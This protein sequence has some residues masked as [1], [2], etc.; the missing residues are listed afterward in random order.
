VATV[1]ALT[2]PPQITDVAPLPASDRAGG[3]LGLLVQALALGATVA[4]I[5]LGR[6]GERTKRSINRGIRHALTLIV[7]AAASGGAVLWAA[8][9]F[10][11]IGG[12]AAGRLYLDFG[13]L[14]LAI[15]ASTAA[16]VALVGPAGALLG[17]LYF[18]LGVI[19]SGSSILPEFLPTFGRVVGQ[20]LPTGA[21][22]TAIRESLYFPAAD[23]TGPIT[24]LALY[25]GIGLLVVLV[26][27][28][29]ANRSHRP[30]F[31]TF[32]SA[33][34]EQTVEDGMNS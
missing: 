25:A 18:T 22:V 24:V 7:Y 27:N 19:I 13:L 2:A 32:G 12:G 26:T 23:R 28:A 29:L 10:G 5:G 20:S 1:K 17:T 8:S 11:V 14:S 4:S 31:V 30:E 16:F 6:I 21:G 9:W 34:D 15:T 33:E 3:S